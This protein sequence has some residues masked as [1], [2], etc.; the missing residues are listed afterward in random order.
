MKEKYV[1][2]MPESFMEDQSVPARW[3]ILGIINGFL[4]N[5]QDFYGSNEWLMSRLGC[6]EQTVSNGMKEL[7]AL[8]AIVCERTRTSRVVKRLTLTNLGHRP[9]ATG[10]SDPNQLGTI[11]ISNA[12]S[13]TAARPKI[14]EVHIVAVSDLEEYSGDSKSPRISGDKRKAYLEMIAWSE[15]ERGF[16][17]PKTLI[18]KQFRAFKLANENQIPRERLMDEWQTMA[19]DKFWQKAGF[20][21][22]NVVQEC[23]KKPL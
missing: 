21:W 9:K 2:S 19:S 11:S 18:M 16:P 1:Y 5:G 8:G 13:D 6:S 10:V 17:F 15:A 12:E 23:L 14:E 22:M 20:D 4:M 3:R 7:E